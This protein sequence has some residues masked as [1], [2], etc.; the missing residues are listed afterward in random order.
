[1]ASGSG[2]ARRR[3]SMTAWLLELRRSFDEA[4]PIEFAT[5]DVGFNRVEVS[6]CRS[7]PYCLVEFSCFLLFSCVQIDRFSDD[8]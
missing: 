1:M 6:V 3:L 5:S 4:G 7:S 8:T 2:S